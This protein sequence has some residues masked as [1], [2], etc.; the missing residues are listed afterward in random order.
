MSLFDLFSGKSSSSSVPKV[1]KTCTFYVEHGYAD[2]YLCLK[3]NRPSFTMD[4]V[5]YD[6]IDEK[7]TCSD[8]FKKSG[9]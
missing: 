8:Y 7:T 2:H 4:E 6:K 9:L 5:K 1:C 3:N